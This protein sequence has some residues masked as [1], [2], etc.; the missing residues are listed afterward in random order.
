FFWLPPL[1]ERPFVQTGRLLGTWVF[2]YRYNFTPLRH[3][4]ALPRSTD[5]LLVN[6]WPPKSLGYVTVFLSLLSLLGWRTA[7]RRV[8][9]AVGVLAVTAAGCAFMTLHLS[10]PVWQRLSLLH[11]IQFPW[12]F[13]GP[14]AFCAAL[15]TGAASSSVI[16]FF[17]LVHRTHWVAAVFCALVILGNLGWF[18]PQHCAAPAETSIASMIAWEHLTD[19]L[20]TTAKGEYLPVWVK[21]MPQHPHLAAAYAEG[22]FVT[23][24]DP[25]SLPEGASIHSARYGALQDQMVIV[26]NTPFRCHLLRLYYPG[27]QAMVDGTRVPLFP[28]PETGIITFDVPAG[29]HRIDIVFRETPLRVAADIVSAFALLLCLM[30]LLRSGPHR[31]TRPLPAKNHTR[32]L[33]LFALLVVAFKL[34]IADRT[35][36][37]WRTTRL[38]E[39]GAISGVG[40]PLQANF[41]QKAALLGVD[42]L[43]QTMAGD[44]TAVVTLY[45]R[46]LQPGNADWQVG[47]TLEGAA[48]E[49]YH[50]IDTRPARWGRSPPPLQEWSPEKY[51]RMDLVLQLP[52]GIV[53]GQY[54][55]KLK[56]FDRISLHP[57]SVLGADGN[58]SGPDLLLGTVSITLPRQP[59]TLDA[60]EVSAAD[61][62]M[63]CGPLQLWQMDSDRS[64][65]A[66][67][68]TVVV[69][70][71]WEAVEPVD[72][73]LRVALQLLD[74]Q[75]TVVW[76]WDMPLVASWFPAD[77]WQVGDRWQGSLGL[78]LPA[79]LESGVYYL[80]AGDNSCD[81][82]VRI[83]LDMTAPDRIW[84]VPAG[85]VAVDA[86][87]GAR[88]AL[89]GYRLG[90]RPVERGQVLELTLAWQTLVQ[91][92]TSYRIYVHVLADDGTRLAQ[93]DGIP[94]GWTRPTTGWAVDEVVLDARPLE[95]PADAQPGSYA[96]YTGVYA[97]GGQRL[98][99]PDGGDRVLLTRI[100][101]E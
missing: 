83:P 50:T 37:P 89:K 54:D 25:A 63:I 38:G 47:F 17:N 59:Y 42:G 13:L 66:P 65:A 18:Y 72:G 79:W 60:L 36:S 8:R 77:L 1:F 51:A 71:V 97:E 85:F 100:D 11:Y 30:M 70:W 4:L 34:V 81:V 75:D 7:N 39:K 20:G 52:A 16:R 15:L 9:W 45:W 10:Q 91:M 82:P 64:A 94:A 41:D 53:P 84:D 44:E 31:V 67:G 68:D 76:A 74:A 78:L 90:A 101:I 3:I 24:I 69:R 48:G 86:S 23:R 5:P 14:A 46:A 62:A 2:D 80:S 28:D 87:L 93:N 12:R 73:D 43:P 27:W 29:R 56:L 35:G 22:E 96:I 19:T 55:M 6:D 21:T 26:S 58:P 57:A 61:P 92:G 33:I 49:T 95:I 99:L 40:Q 32:F 88:L 98:R